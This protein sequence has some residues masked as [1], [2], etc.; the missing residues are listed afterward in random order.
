MIYLDAQMNMPNVTLHADSFIE[1]ETNL[2]QHHKYN[3]TTSISYIY[4]LH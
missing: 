3:I 1:L 4:F 2:I